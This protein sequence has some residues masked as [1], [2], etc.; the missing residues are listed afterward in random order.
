MIRTPIA[1]TASKGAVDAAD[2]SLA[3]DSAAEAEARRSE[4]EAE[5]PRRSPAE[6]PVKP[7]VEEEMAVED[8]IWE[9]A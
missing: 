5:A 7:E 6:R 3:L 2:S 8:W 1:M 4:V 9:A